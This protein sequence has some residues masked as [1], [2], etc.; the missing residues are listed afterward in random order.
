MDTKV[1][2]GSD[3]D[4]DVEDDDMSDDDDDDEKYLQ[5]REI[6]YKVSSNIK[7]CQRNLITALSKG[8]IMH[9]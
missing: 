6:I 8:C 3:D 9:L 5:V 4:D 2:S 1:I 7:L